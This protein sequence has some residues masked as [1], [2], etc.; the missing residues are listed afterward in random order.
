MKQIKVN[1]ILYVMDTE[2]YQITEDT[3]VDI[4]CVPEDHYDEYVAAQ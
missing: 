1:N 2:A 3:D 4:I